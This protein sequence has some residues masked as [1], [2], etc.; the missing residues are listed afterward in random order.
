MTC[1]V[2][3]SSSL[4][5]AVLPNL[6]LTTLLPKRDASGTVTTFTPWKKT[7]PA[8]LRAFA[9]VTSSTQHV[10]TFSVFSEKYLP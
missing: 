5:A 2:H 6:A 7:D 3:P 8:C 4:S 9:Q 1:A 10:L